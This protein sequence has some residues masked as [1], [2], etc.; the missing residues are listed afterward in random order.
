MTG[1]PAVGH[2]LVVPRAAERDDLAPVFSALTALREAG[3]A[4]RRDLRH[5]VAAADGVPLERVNA[6]HATARLQLDPTD[7]RSLL[8]LLQRGHPGDQTPLVRGLDYLEPE[9]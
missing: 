8:M 6:L 1:E 3:L 5:T 2:V 7:R 4:R 9:G